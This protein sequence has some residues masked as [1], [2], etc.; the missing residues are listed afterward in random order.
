[1]SDKVM[2]YNENCCQA[3][4]VHWQATKDKNWEHVDSTCYSEEDVAWAKSK[5]RNPDK[6]SRHIYRTAKTIVEYFEGEI[7]NIRGGV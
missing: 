3:G 7:R 4:D 1:M 6:S 2:I 5:L